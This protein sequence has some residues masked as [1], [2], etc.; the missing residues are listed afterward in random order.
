[1]RMNTLGAALAAGAIAVLGAAC[2]QSNEV[3]IETTG[4]G[5]N[6][7]PSEQMERTMNMQQQMVNQL[8][9]QQGQ[10]QADGEDQ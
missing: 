5:A 3:D 2:G 6:Q 10:G 8:Q 7:P 4:D 1:M 9:E